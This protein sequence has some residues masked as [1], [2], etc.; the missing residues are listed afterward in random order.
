MKI[1]QKTN[2]PLVLS[3]AKVISSSFIF[4]WI[5]PLGIQEILSSTLFNRY[6]HI[7]LSEIYESGSPLKIFLF[8]LFIFGIHY[9]KNQSFNLYSFNCLLFLGCYQL[10]FQFEELI[11]NTYFS[12]VLF[13][14]IL[15]LCFYRDENENIP[16]IN[17]HIYFVTIGIQVLIFSPPINP[18]WSPSEWMKVSRGYFGIFEGK[19]QFSAFITP[20]SVRTGLYDFIFGGSTYLFGV[21]I[22]YYILKI[23]SLLI[24]YFGLIN[25]FEA[26][27]LPRIYH[28]LVLSLFALQQ[29][30]IAGNE[31][32]GIA[33]EDRFA[34]GFAIIG[35]SFWLLDKKKKMVIFFVLSSYFHVQVG[36][37][38]FIFISFIDLLSKSPIKEIL[39]NLTSYLTFAFP[40]IFFTLAKLVFGGDPI[41]YAFDKKS[42]WVY[43]FKFQQ[44][45]I[46]PF[47]VENGELPEWVIKNWSLGFSRILFWSLFSLILL[48]S[49]KKMR[50]RK[51]LLFFMIFHAIALLAHYVDSLS[52]DPGRIGSLFLFRHDTVFYLIILILIFREISTK[53]G[54]KPILLVLISSLI[55][56]GGVNKNISADKKYTEIHNRLQP[57]IDYLNTNDLG[58]VIIDPNVELYTGE[59]EL[60]TKTPTFVTT[61]YISND[62][63]NFPIWY[64]RHE[65][66]GRFF[67][68]ECSIISDLPI[69]H[70]ISTVDSKNKEC[71]E[72]IFENND[73]SIFKITSL[74][75]SY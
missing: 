29:D 38:W 15:L 60:R 69:Y 75:F 71:G 56:I 14:G 27:D 50:E 64:T 17:N 43:T 49:I 41:V 26:L 8:Y 20:N 30:L 13:I 57:T 4:L 74:D 40:V 59:I 61:K 33:E 72:L 35:L 45:H 6:S 70:Y 2:T 5:K 21:D 12:F 73:Y 63:S 24:I 67:G 58:T 44:Y 68:G 36:F 16:T 48:S 19:N 65:V 52:Q 46:A 7:S 18:G 42:S 25:I 11:N 55:F 39:K 31:I 51:I 53:E 54:V 23:S 3:L 37:F 28:F 47:P 10:I 1:F 34:I 32:L 22:G 66:R 62:L 9:K